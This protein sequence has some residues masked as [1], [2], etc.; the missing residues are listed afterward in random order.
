MVG[1]ASVVSDTALFDSVVVGLKALNINPYLFTVVASGSFA[2][3]T[4]EANTAVILFIQTFGRH[5][6]G[7]AAI[8]IGAV[9]RLSI[10]SSA[11]LDSLPH[12][13]NVLMNLRVFGLDHKTGYKYVFLTSIVIPSVNT[14]VGLAA[15]LIFGG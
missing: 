5:F 10:M 4:A 2:I 3:V 11:G 15:Q 13:G 1:F 8:D 9:H 7:N 14:A 6:M 12:S